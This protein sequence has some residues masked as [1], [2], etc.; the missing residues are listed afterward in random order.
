MYVF[1]FFPAYFLTPCDV[2]VSL[3]LC[4]TPTPEVL[5][6]CAEVA[7]D[8]I[9]DTK[10]RSMFFIGFGMLPQHSWLENGLDVFPIENGDIP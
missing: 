8:S 3:S 10:A 5:Q 6:E 4:K 7:C 2:K 1:H 9:F